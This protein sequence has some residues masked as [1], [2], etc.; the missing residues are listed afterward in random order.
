MQTTGEN[1]TLR[2][3][4]QETLS[5][6]RN[7]DEI[8][9]SLAAD[10][11]AIDW[12]FHELHTS[13]YSSKYLAD[14]LWRHYSNDSR[15]RLWKNRAFR[16]YLGEDGMESEGVYRF[17][18]EHEPNHPWLDP[19]MEQCAY[20][21]CDFDWGIYFGKDFKSHLK[22]R[23]EQRIGIIG[24]A[25]SHVRNI[26]N[27]DTETLKQW[28]A[29]FR[30]S[31]AIKLAAAR[32][33]FARNEFDFLFEGDI[34]Y[35]VEQE[36]MG[37]LRNKQAYPLLAAAQNTLIEG[38]YNSLALSLLLENCSSESEFVALYERAAELGWHNNGRFIKKIKELGSALPLSVVRRVIMNDIDCRYGTPDAVRI[39]FSR[40]NEDPSIL[41]CIKSLVT[42][43]TS[44]DSFFKSLLYLL[45]NNWDRNWIRDITLMFNE[46]NDWCNYNLL[47]RIGDEECI[48]EVL[49]DI[50]SVLKSEARS[51]LDAAGRYLYKDPR[52]KKILIEK[53]RS[54]CKSASQW[55]ALRYSDDPE[56]QDTLEAKLKGPTLTKLIQTLCIQEAML[57]F[58]REQ[59]LES[60]NN[61]ARLYSVHCDAILALR[62]VREELAM[63][64]TKHWQQMIDSYQGSFSSVYSMW[65]SWEPVLDQVIAKIRTGEI[66]HG[67]REL[68]LHLSDYADVSDALQDGIRAVMGNPNS[69]NM[70]DV[71]DS[72][73]LLGLIYGNKPETVAF[74]KEIVEKES[75]SQNYGAEAAFAEVLRLGSR[76]EEEFQW[77]LRTLRLATYDPRILLH[78]FG[79]GSNVVDALRI[80]SLSNDNPALANASMSLLLHEFSE[81]VPLN[82]R[83]ALEA[84][85]TN[86]REH[87]FADLSTK[88]PGYLG[89]LIHFTLNDPDAPVRKSALSALRK[90]VIWY[91][92]LE[93]WIDRE[94][95][96][97][98]LQ[99]GELTE[100][101]A[102]LL[103]KWFPEDESVAECIIDGVSR[104][105]NTKLL[106]TLAESFG[107]TTVATSFLL[108]TV[109]KSQ[110]IANSLSVIPR[111]TCRRCLGFD[112]EEYATLLIRLHYPPFDQLLEAKALVANILNDP[113]IEIGKAYG[114][115]KAVTYGLN[116][117]EKLLHYEKI[118]RN[119]AYNRNQACGAL[120]SEAIEDGA[121]LELL[122]KLLND[123]NQELRKTVARTCKSFYFTDTKRNKHIHLL[124][125]EIEHLPEC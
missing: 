86:A 26:A 6:L 77:A 90:G 10:P 72:I 17:I 31:K 45:D 32:E 62:H 85:S 104:F 54:N 58:I 36:V 91:K 117:A 61:S 20:D 80:F 22:D 13:E 121:A 87:F 82:N 97:K 14:F 98:C 5:G 12:L 2:A 119:E 100:M 30:F 93:N 75:T 8:P 55:V 43:C 3:L 37:M 71:V 41:D 79:R 25:A 69:S 120:V 42:N 35:H 63:E 65:F 88:L 70:M 116:H 16:P 96:L 106:R 122:E 47:A 73:L 15:F 39:L 1:V 125:H 21:F 19:F 60:L 94:F 4:S 107:K 109:R 23:F 59:F 92:S 123:S 48:Q 46:K 38:K 103:E 101:A 44:S 33:L 99:R 49:Q 112:C 108:E 9:D 67:L 66:N 115:I 51:A 7:E 83:A 53:A 110:Q 34:S 74:F 78:F 102:D 52:V 89:E 40:V 124:L 114:L 76:G 113:W 27:I 111:C 81:A 64:T 68:I 84:M 105:P 57:P 24:A 95:A 50:D 28:V 11:Q 118:I 56:A 18:E 29:S